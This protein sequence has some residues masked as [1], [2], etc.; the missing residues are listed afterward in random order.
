M[1]RARSNRFTRAPGTTGT[2]RDATASRA[3]PGRHRRNLDEV[4]GSAPALVTDP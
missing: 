2:R 3:P 1:D 4:P